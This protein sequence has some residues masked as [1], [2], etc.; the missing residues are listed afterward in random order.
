MTDWFEW[1][2]LHAGPAPA[3]SDADCAVI[4][5]LVDRQPADLDARGVEDSA[6][7]A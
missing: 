1:A 3:L 4:A 6:A 5:S 7:A 2:R